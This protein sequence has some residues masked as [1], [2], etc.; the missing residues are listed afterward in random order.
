MGTS[1]FNSCMFQG[2]SL[3]NVNTIS[4]IENSRY[5]VNTAKN[6]AST[7]GTTTKRSTTRNQVLGEISFDFHKGVPNSNRYSNKDHT[8]FSDNFKAK[9]L[10]PSVDLTD[11]NIMSRSNEQNLN[12]SNSTVMKL[13]KFDSKEIDSIGDKN[14]DVGL[15]Y[16]EGQIDS[17][18]RSS[19]QREEFQNLLSEA[20]EDIMNSKE[21]KPT[22]SLPKLR[23]GQLPQEIPTMPM[24]S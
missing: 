5:L 20:T 11:L 12:I 24:V 19:I 7:E 14:F 4:C 13:L 3:D 15:E 21:M 8:R 1:V 10:N 23:A 2:E 6:Q 17:Q 9:N 16:S 22:T 18:R